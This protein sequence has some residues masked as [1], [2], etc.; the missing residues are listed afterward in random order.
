MIAAPH[1]LR[2]LFVRDKPHIP[3]RLWQASVDRLAFLE[4]LTADERLR[5]KA[6]CETFLQRK[7][8]SG[9]AG[10][11]I[12]NDIAVAIAIQAC[13]PVL[14][15]TLDLYHD[16]PGVIVYPSEFIVP[17]SE[18]DDA[19]VVHEW[20]EP[21]AGEAVGAGGAVVLSWE[22]VEDAAELAEGY[23]VVIH[24]FAHKIDMGRS[25]A[26]GC[27]PFLADYHRGL[28]PRQWQQVFSAAYDDFTRR[29]E[30][31]ERRLARTVRASRHDAGDDDPFGQLPL[32]PYAA[33]DPA[34]FFAVASEVFFL[35]PLPLHEDYPEVYRLLAR[36]Y[37]QETL[38][39][40][41]A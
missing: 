34:E 25:D 24:E 6:L 23:N 9:A 28:D 5:L 35:A 12:G 27:P 7:P 30:H 19:G 16:M 31:I 40:D 41:A 13:L 26:N 3:D 36:Y 21:L 15:L 20:Q 2:R 18:I 14:H 1:W 8:I 39:P 22:D 37:R 33:S 38:A 29:V 4:R 32:D 17:R 10:L 11:E